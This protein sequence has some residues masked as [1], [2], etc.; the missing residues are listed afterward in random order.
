MVN[1]AK[2]MEVDGVQRQ[3]K[4][5]QDV[6]KNKVARGASSGKAA[7]KEAKMN[8]RKQKKIFAKMIRNK[9]TAAEFSNHRPYA[10]KNTTEN[11]VKNCY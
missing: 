2:A 10:S 11:L 9:K 8:E 6:A 7:K 4:H 5:K 3:E 1:R